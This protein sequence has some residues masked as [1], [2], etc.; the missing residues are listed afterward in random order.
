VLGI[1]ALGVVGSTLRIEYT[2]T[3][4][5]YKVIFNDGKGS[6]NPVGHYR[7]GNN[8][9]YYYRNCSG[10]FS[11][12]CKEI[13]EGVLPSEFEPL[14]KDIAKVT[15]NGEVFIYLKQSNVTDD[16]ANPNN[17]R[18]LER[19]E[20]YPLYFSDDEYLYYVS[21]DLIHDYGK[22]SSLRN[23]SKDANT[24]EASKHILFPIKL[25][26]GDV[27]ETPTEFQLPFDPADCG[28]GASFRT[29]VLFL[30]NK[31]YL[32]GALV[33]GADAQ[34]FEE[35]TYDGGGLRAVGPWFKDKNNVYY[36][37]HVVVGGDPNTIK[38]NSK[39]EKRAGISHQIL[40]ELL[41][42]MRMFIM[43]TSIK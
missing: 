38:I 39:G 34:T 18:A 40:H 2:E 7:V 25:S 16:V 30:N 26:A 22:L 24:R 19:M 3:Q 43:L 14:S 8:S 36:N 42:I 21:D 10:P 20:S 28:G 12:W 1:S 31:V 9:V 11:I 29:R 35:I 17:F 15:K 5:D 32:N 27:Y 41:Q 6:S 4:K 13:L 37:G 33:P 23:D